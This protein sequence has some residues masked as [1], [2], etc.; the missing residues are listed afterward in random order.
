M[1]ANGHAR[2]MTTFA[3]RAVQVFR[4]MKVQKSFSECTGDRIRS[5]LG[6]LAH[7]KAPAA[8]AASE[9]SIAAEQEPSKA[10]EP[11]L[12]DAPES[13]EPP[14]SNASPDSAAELLQHYIAAKAPE[15]GSA[16]KSPEASGQDDARFAPLTGRDVVSGAQ[17]MMPGGKKGYYW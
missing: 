15:P 8:Q 3:S 6:P 13:S 4:D 7:D 1:K 17:R 11:A 5:V 16:E 9:R 14:V 2:F 10:A 12:Q